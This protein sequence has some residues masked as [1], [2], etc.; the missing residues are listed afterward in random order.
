MP[1]IVPLQAAQIEFPQ[2]TFVSALT[3][4]EQKA[5][6]HVRDNAGVDLCLKII[7]PNYAIERVGR[8]II[9]LQGLIS[10]NVV[11]LIEYT[12]S[13]T[14]GHLRHFIVEEFVIGTDLAG[15]LN[16]QPWTR[17]EC[18]DFFAALCDGLAA[19]DGANIVHRDLKPTN[20]RVR[21]NGA[22]VIIDFGLA[23]LLELP[24]LTNTSQGAAIGTPQFFAPERFDGT[25][26][27]IDHRTD[28]FALGTMLYE[29]LTGSPPFY[30]PGIS[31]SQL[32]DAVVT[33]EEFANRVQF[34]SL[35][36]NWQ[37]LLKK[38][39]AKQ[40][41]NRPAH[42]EQVASILRKLRNV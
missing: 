3:P 25:K 9:A 39:L 31:Y 6:F 13:S 21:E 18:S 33:S 34:Q 38:L 1:F 37:T 24:D 2:Y 27:D 20:I 16:G 26:R 32:R 23:R 11:R 36:A 17:A 10:P 42:G 12:Y 19:L 22:P 15:R 7:S 40:R 29:A 35:P 28:L 14:S 5:A 41:A 30:Q 8:E 4:S